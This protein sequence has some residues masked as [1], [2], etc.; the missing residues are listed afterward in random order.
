MPRAERPAGAP[1][2]CAL[3]QFDSYMEEIDGALHGRRWGRTV[4]VLGTG[5]L[6]INTRGQPLGSER[7]SWARSPATWRASTNASRGDP[8][9]GNQRVDDARGRSPACR[10][11][12][13]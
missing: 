11:T 2:C 13:V 4:W 1:D 3:T 9:L 8:P 10:P 7:E 12:C 6:K 5:Y